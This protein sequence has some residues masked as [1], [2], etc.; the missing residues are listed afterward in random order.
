[1]ARGV[2]MNSL[3]ALH[4]YNEVEDHTPVRVAYLHAFGV[5]EALRRASEH[6]EHG[7]KRVSA[8]KVRINAGVQIP[9]GMMLS[10]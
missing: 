7:E 1:M 2:R 8:H 4:F 3:W 5:D 9:P 10:R 6:W